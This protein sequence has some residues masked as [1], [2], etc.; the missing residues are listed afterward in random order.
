VKDYHRMM[1]ILFEQNPSIFLFGLP[2]LYGVS[3]DI[4]GFGAAA[5]KLLRLTAVRFK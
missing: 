5:D 2:S 1:E 3:D 4:S